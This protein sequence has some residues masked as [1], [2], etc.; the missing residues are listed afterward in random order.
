MG[1]PL[2]GGNT[3]ENWLYTPHTHTHIPA[4][5][6]ERLA[7]HTSPEQHYRADSVG[8]VVGELAL[9]V[10]EWTSWSHP[11]HLTRGGMGEE[12]MP[13]TPCPSISVAGERA[14]P[15]VMRTSELAQHPASCSSAKAG[16]APHP[17]NTEEL[18]L[19]AAA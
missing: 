1:P 5:A 13:S 19:L 4:T 3:K 12:K 6:V 9:R 8:K 14:G 18:V 11:L 17:G 10:S 15:A 7:P 2:T 16:P